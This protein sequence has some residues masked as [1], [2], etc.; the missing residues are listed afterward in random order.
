MAQ[1][2]NSKVFSNGK[3]TCYFFDDSFSLLDDKYTRIMHAKSELK[4]SQESFEQI[5]K[6]YEMFTETLK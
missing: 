6:C 4:P 5:V 1:Q 2:E 3:Y